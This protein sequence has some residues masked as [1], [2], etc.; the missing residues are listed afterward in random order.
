MNII[1]LIVISYNLESNRP[2]ILSLNDN[3]LILPEI[4]NNTSLS[5]SDNLKELIKEYLY[6]DFD[7]LE[8]R[9]YDTRNIN[10]NSELYYIC[11]IPYQY[12]NI[13]LQG[14]LID[15][16]SIIDDKFFTKAKYIL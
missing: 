9:L 7:W 10:D 15:A 8:M 1:K 3:D 16:E 6:V 4:E 14:K 2:S 13:I 12:Q 11:S 5:I